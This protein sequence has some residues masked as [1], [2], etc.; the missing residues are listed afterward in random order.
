MP[1]RYGG[2][3][4]QELRHQLFPFLLSGGFRDAMGGA[5]SGKITDEMHTQRDQIML[6]RWS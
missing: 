2:K 5:C 4:V 6:L 1:P 3:I